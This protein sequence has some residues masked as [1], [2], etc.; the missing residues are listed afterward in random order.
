MRSTC[1]KSKR[2]SVYIKGLI[3]EKELKFLVDT[4]SEV[5]ML[6]VSMAEGLR[7]DPVPQMLRA[8][9]GSEITVVG[10]VTTSIRFARKLRRNVDLIVC[11]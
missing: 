7:I 3:D 1:G 5:N 8:A 9:N 6:P 4:G 11:E 10:Q 2:R